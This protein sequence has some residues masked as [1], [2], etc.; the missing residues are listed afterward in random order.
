MVGSDD[1]R[2]NQG[3][4]GIC[5]CH[6][7]LY[8]FIYMSLICIQYEEVNILCY[9]LN[10]DKIRVRNKMRTDLGYTILHPIHGCSSAAKKTGLQTIF[11]QSSQCSLSDELYFA[12]EECRHNQAWVGGI[13]LVQGIITPELTAG[14]NF[15]V[16]HKNAPRNE[17]T[18]IQP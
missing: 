18:R 2:S 14:A 9:A 1:S 4:V 3:E 8:V 11:R 13:R 6:H 17:S 5:G 10:Y 12:V 15:A 16:T 7:T